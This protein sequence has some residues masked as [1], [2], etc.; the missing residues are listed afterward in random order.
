MLTP[1]GT[2]LIVAACGAQATAPPESGPLRVTHGIRAAV[3]FDASDSAFAVA[4]LGYAD[5]ETPDV[6]HKLGATSTSPFVVR[7][8]ATR[9]QLTAYWRVLWRQPTLAPECWMIGSATR[10]TVALLSPRTW[11]DSACGHDATDAAATRRIVKHEIVHVVHRRLHPSASFASQQIWWLVEGLAAGYD[12]A[13]SLADYLVSRWP[14]RLPA[15]L[16][17][18]TQDELLLLLGVG[19]S[20]LLSAWKASIV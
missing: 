10:D 16:R 1:L 9:A 5:D 6:E 3:Q 15:L 12:V 4:M 18:S 14:D 7:L 11:R 13:G 20:E 19:E 8:F 17:V 2:L